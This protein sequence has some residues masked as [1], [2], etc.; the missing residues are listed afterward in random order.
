MDITRRHQI[1]AKEPQRN[2]MPTSLLGV[3]VSDAI[4]CR[5][6]SLARKGEYAVAESLLKQ[7]VGSEN[8]SSRALDL[9]ARIYAQQGRFSEAETFWKRALELEPNNTLYLAGLNRIAQIQGR[10][11]RASVPLSMVVAFIAILLVCIV[12]FVVR[13]QIIHLRELLLREVAQANSSVIESIRESNMKTILYLEE[14][15]DRVKTL[16]MASQLTIQL[17]GASVKTEQ[18][19]LI[20]SFHDGLFLSGAHLKPE[21]KT[22]LS[23]L[24]EQLRPHA[25]YISIRI[26]GHTDNL[27]VTK[28]WLYRDNA[29]LGMARAVTVANFLSR[30]A[31]L[32][33]NIFLLQSAGKSQPPYPNDTSENRLRNRTVVIYI[34][35]VENRLGGEL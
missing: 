3:L 33:M 6:A 23:Q 2:T 12:G 28:G 25:S 19:N 5:A 24:G 10:P 21:V 18:D 35:A 31:G 1:K 8:E 17:D 20:I 27:P 9:L 32:P 7:L 29:A 26:V 13:E 34:S 4:L 14:K 30:N 22:L 11:L 16:S 15:V